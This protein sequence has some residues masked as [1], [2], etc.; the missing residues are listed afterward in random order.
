MS[1]LDTLFGSGQKSGPPPAPVPTPAPSPLFGPPQQS[2]SLLDLLTPKVAPKPVAPPPPTAL[3][4][5]GLS[6]AKPVNPLIKS[7]IP[8]AV[9]DYNKFSA[10]KAV[11]EAAKTQKKQ[12]TGLSVLSPNLQP[13]PKSKPNTLDKLGSDLRESLLGGVMDVIGTHGAPGHG[14]DITE[15]AQQYIKNGQ[16]D[17]ATK[18]LQSPQMQEAIDSEKRGA[19]TNPITGNIDPVKV[20]DQEN[21]PGP[22]EGFARGSLQG[23][24]R[25]I[26]TMALG[27]GA[28]TA[29]K[30]LGIADALGISAGVSEAGGNALRPTLAALGAKAGYRAVGAELGQVGGSLIAFNHLYTGLRSQTLD[31]LKKN[32]VEDLKSLP[33]NLIIG[34]GLHFGLKGV[35]KAAQSFKTFSDGLKASGIDATPEK[36]HDFIGGKVEDP[37]MQDVW[38]RLPA[39]QRT[40]MMQSFIGE[41]RLMTYKPGE[42][43]KSGTKENR[44]AG[45]RGGQPDPKL[46]QMQDDL[47]SIRQEKENHQQMLDTDF[48][49]ALK[50]GRY[51]DKTTGTLPDVTG[52]SGK[53]KYVKSGDTIGREL[54]GIDDTEAV[55]A[56]YEKAVETKQK[57]QQMTEMER[58]KTEEIKQ[59]TQTLPDLPERGFLQSVKESDTAGP[60]KEKVKQLEPQTYEPVTNASA[61]KTADEIIKQSPESAREQ[62]S[63]DAPPSA[64]KGAIAVRLAKYYED[65]ARTAGIAGDTAGMEKHFDRAVE[66]IDTYDKQLREA[67]RFVQAASLWS[68]VSPEGMLRKA[69]REIENANSEKG[70]LKKFLK[71][72]DLELTPEDKRFILKEMGDAGK[73]PEGSVE[74]QN[75]VIGVLQK[76]ADKIPVSASEMF[77]AYRYQNMLSSPQTQLRNIYSNLLQTYFTRPADLAL[78]SGVDWVKSTLTGKEREIYASDVPKYFKGVMN[79]QIDALHAASEAFAGKTP[80]GRI[81]STKTISNTIRALR[82]KNVPKALTVTT[83][84]L[85]AVDKYFS[86]LIM[87]GERTRLQGRGLSAGAIDTKAAELAEKTLFRGELKADPD[88]PVLSRALTSLGQSILELRRKPVIGKP[89]SWFVPFVTTPIR[90]AKTAVESSPLG[91]IGGKY[92]S[93]QVAKAAVGSLI[94]MGGAWMAMNNKTTWAAPTDK[95]AKEAFYA[96]GRKPYSVRIGDKW[97]PMWYFGPYAFAMA[98]PAA[99]KH[100]EQDSKDKLTTGQLSK[101]GSITADLAKFLGSQSPLQGMTG[102]F[103]MIQGDTDYTTASNLGFTAGQV[104]PLEGLLRYVNKIVDPVYRKASTFS[105]SI[106]SGLPGFSKDLPAYK[107]SKGNDEK[108][109]P[110]NLILPYD[111]GK[112]DNMFEKA[113]NDLTKKTQSKTLLNKQKSIAKDTSLTAKQRATKLKSLKNGGGLFDGVPVLDSLFSGEEKDTQLPAFNPP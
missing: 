13:L 21:P 79:S 15:L 42:Q 27:A 90:V 91:L 30:G 113:Y 105:G 58:A 109:D 33:M 52:E 89:F 16:L 88:A 77:D 68:N 67:G 12:S 48:A 101:I 35:N 78:G 104:I 50:L 9:D 76:I 69:V 63:V 18:L 73:L 29:M 19:I 70:M 26:P 46:R 44:L 87:G 110:L 36:I 22:I 112:S 86:T 3:S 45:L 39:E 32:E 54:T 64:E 108:R 61:L 107:D 43:V 37:A 60:L 98:I 17:E 99:I 14:G 106:E 72:K 11:E 111:L 6:S 53:G 96:A 100:Y 55:R 82:Q 7:V 81:D 25:L 38:T 65:Q 74:R 20:E 1:F 93:E 4:I 92:G 83:R 59:Y 23:I 62:L 41:N 95:A 94:S 24:E 103:R 80:H 56:H 5:L 71:T 85:E 75:K 102:F 57:L 28:G 8:S 97:V 49:G 66:V 51:V 2:S 10:Q 47:A 40:T 84:M 34:Y 31:E